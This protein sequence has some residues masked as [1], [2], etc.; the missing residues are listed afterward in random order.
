MKK[1]KPSNRYRVSA[2]YRDYLYPDYDAKVTKLVGRKSDGSGMGFGE[3]DVDFLFGTLAGALTAFKKLI[4]DH[5]IV[6]VGI[7][8]DLWA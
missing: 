4:R 7:H 3:R 5:N 6:S 8:R 2:S 1:R